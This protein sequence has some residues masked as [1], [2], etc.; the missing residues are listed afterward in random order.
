VSRAQGEAQDHWHVAGYAFDAIGP[1]KSRASFALC[2]GKVGL[3]QMVGQTLIG[4]HERHHA[5]TLRLR[6]SDHAAA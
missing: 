5:T 2:T 4:K 6:D 1:D 3:E